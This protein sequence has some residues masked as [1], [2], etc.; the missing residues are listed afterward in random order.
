V[1]NDFDIG[2][3]TWVKEEIDKSLH[4]VLEN[5]NKYGENISDTAFL[6]YAQTHVYQASGALDMVGLEG[7]K[8]FCAELEKCIS[9]L[10]KNEI[11]TTP[12]LNAQLVHAVNALLAYLD[13]LMKGARDVP[14]R[15]FDAL[16]PIV[17]AQGGLLEKV[18]C[19]SRT[20]V[21]PHQR[22]F[23]RLSWTIPPMLNLLQNNDL[24]TKNH[25]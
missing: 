23:L 3:L 5:L 9:K 4:T 17:A 19:S 13:S 10:E 6:R 1:S 2:P 20:P 15:L 12:E 21:M 8:F 16:A 18:I 25:C 7:C 22:I 14:L 24:T 11:A